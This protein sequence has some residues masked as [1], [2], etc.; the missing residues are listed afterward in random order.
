MVIKLSEGMRF[1]HNP[2]E[3]G[4]EFTIRKHDFYDDGQPIWCAVTEKCI[5]PL[6]EIIL[7]EYIPMVDGKW[8]NE[9]NEY[10]E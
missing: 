1:Q 7:G 4:N 9:P 5:Y 6:S 2:I 3:K 10:V 8:I